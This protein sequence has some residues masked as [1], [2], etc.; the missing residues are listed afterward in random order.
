MEGSRSKKHHTVPQF[1]LRNFA[2]ADGQ[3]VE[4]DLDLL[5]SY[6]RTP[7]QVGHTKDFYTIERSNGPSDEVERILA[8]IE[9]VASGAVRK[10]QTP[11][12]TITMAELD[13][14]VLLVAVQRQRT[15]ANRAHMVD[16]IDRTEE[17]ARH[18]AK[19]HGLDPD[20]AMT[21]LSPEL[22]EARGNNFMNGF[23]LDSV[24]MIYPLMRRRG[25]SVMRRETGGPKFV[26][27]DNPVVISDLRE[28]KGPPY[29]PLIPY[30]EDSKLTM[31]LSPDL[32]LVSYYEPEMSK[33]AYLPAELVEF[34]NHE[35]LRNS[36]R[37]LYGSE[38]DFY[39][40][41][42]GSRVLSWDDWVEDQREARAK[43]PPIQ[44]S[45]PNR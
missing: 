13:A 20:E 24:K 26:I 15:P 2:G 40:G 22:E 35:Q 4:F 3:L 39:W 18:V 11:R 27:S 36:E 31:P 19:S 12:S 7:A 44:T 23:M 33:E 28:D 9:N 38:T 29:F 5:K 42:L 43:E 17:L 34:V 41:R 32:I 8:N 37:R 21:N 16:F 6:R 14:L 25:W 10:L 1:L 30:G 45:D